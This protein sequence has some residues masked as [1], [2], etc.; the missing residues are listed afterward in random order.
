MAFLKWISDKD[1]K[2]EV[3]RLL[4]KA[5]EAKRSKE[6]K[7]GKNVIDPFSAM[8]EIAGFDLD[9][10][11]WIKNETNRQAQKALQ[12]HIGDFH[13]NILG[14]SKGWDNMKIGNV[15]DLISLNNNIIAEVK[16]KHN[17]VTKGKLADLYQSLHNKV[18]PKS[19][20]Y[21]GCTAYYV[22]IIPQKPNRYDIEFT[23][24]NKEEGHK[25]PS[26]PKIREIDGASFYHLVTGHKNA[27]EE[28]FDVLP[29]VILECSKGKYKIRDKEKLK[30]FFNAAYIK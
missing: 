8:F 5:E 28:L 27:L 12:N 17:T 10:D 9:Y 15:M 18:M 14:Y 2:E 16:N 3:F 29:D 1:L 22:V 21:K 25:C 24:S 20:K 19:S 26:N 4:Q 6:K 7:F 30:A 23:P 13:Q 11:T